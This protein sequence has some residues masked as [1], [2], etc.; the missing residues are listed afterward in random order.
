[1]RLINPLGIRKRTLDSHVIF[2]F[3]NSTTNRGTT[4]RTFNLSST[5]SARTFITITSSGLSPYSLHVGQ[6][7]RTIHTLVSRTR[8]LC[9]F[10]VGATVKHF[11]A[12][13]AAKRV[14]TIGTITPLV[15][16]VHSHSLLSLC[17]HGTIH[18]VNISLSVVRHRI[19]S[20]QHGLRIQSRSTCTPGH[21]FTNGTKTTIRPHVRRNAGPC[22]GP[23]TQGTLRR[24][25]TTRR[26]CC[27]VSSTIFVYRRRFVTALVRIPLTISPA[28]F[29]DLALSDFVAPMFHALF[30][31][32]TT[33][34]KLPSTS[35]PRKL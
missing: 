12:A 23:S 26:S 3:S 18:R 5:F 31:T 6:N 32:I 11:S 28:L 4:V 29:T 22:T 25:S 13:C 19:H 20:T 7:G 14:N 16:R 8:P 17:S 30:R 34:K 24:H 2:A 10:I 21:H 27:H 9:S 33:T 1:M 35:A 15:T